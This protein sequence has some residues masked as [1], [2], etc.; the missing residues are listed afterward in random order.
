MNDWIEK[1]WDRHMAYATAYYVDVEK[2][3]KIFDSALEK[4]VKYG[5]LSIEDQN[6]IDMAMDEFED[7]F[8]SVIRLGRKM[9]ERMNYN[10]FSIL[11]EIEGFG[12]TVYNVND[13]KEI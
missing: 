9:Y 11:R 6:M 5:E 13:F 2:P 3:V 7:G 10:H 4:I 1:R 8:N 12:E